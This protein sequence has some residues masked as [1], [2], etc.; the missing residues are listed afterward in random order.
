MSNQ[1]WDTAPD[2]QID[3][4]ATYAVILETSRGTIELELYPQH[5]PQAVNNFVFLTGQGFYDGVAF[6]RVIADFMVQGGDPTGSGSGGPGYR[7]DCE[8]ADN[9]LIHER[10]VISMANAGPNTNG[11]QF[12]ITH[13]ACP[14]LDGGHTVFGKVTAGLDVVDA[15]EQGDT[16]DKVSV[17]E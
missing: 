10:G 13:V 9:P 17:T 3:V 4:S 14:H 1:Q 6:H 7:F 16:M 2:M 11:S 15:I 8:T 5:A 12:F